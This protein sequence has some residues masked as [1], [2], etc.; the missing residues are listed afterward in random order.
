[1][2]KIIALNKEWL[3]SPLYKSEYLDVDCLA[4]DFASV[5]LPHANIEIPNN[6]FNAEKTRFIST[7]KRYLRLPSSYNGSKLV[8]GFEGILSYAEIYVNGVFVTSH[9]GETPFDVDIT[10]PIKYDYDNIILIKTDS[11]IR[12]DIPSPGF[13]DPVI[14]YGGIHRDVF[15][16][17]YKGEIIAD[18]FIKT[19]DVLDDQKTIEIDV[20]LCEF[21]PDTFVN[22][23]IMDGDGEVVDTLP[24]KA[25]L[26]AK[27]SLRGS[28]SDVVLWDTENPCLYT[29]KI[30]LSRGEKVL[31]TLSQN[32]GFSEK[33]FT[34]TG[35]YLN[36]QPLKLIGLNRVDA[37][38][39]VG[40]SACE[41]MQIEDANLI[42]YTLGCNVVRMLG[43]ASRDF[44]LHCDKI[45][46]LVIEDIASDGYLGKGMWREVLLNNIEEMV[47]RDRNSP[48]IICWG[49]RPSNSPDC[50]ELFFKTSTAAKT[51]DPTRQ[52]LGTRNF[53]GSHM[54][55]D[56]F[57][58][59][60]YNKKRGAV[61]SLTKTGKM[62]VP[63]LV[64]EHTGKSF[65]TKMHDK[66]SV[67]LEQA[68]RHLKIIDQ[69]L[70]SKKICGAIGMSLSDFHSIQYKGCGD[71]INYYG[72][73]DIYRNPKLAFYAYQS[74][75]AKK[76][77]IKL[78]SDMSSDE[79]SL[80]LYAF[81][82]CDY[83]K[84]YRREKDSEAYKEVGTFYPN[85]KKFSSLP[86]P[87]IKL[88]DMLG[89][90][91]IGEGFSKYES[92]LFK[93]LCKAAAE[94]NILN[95]G[96]INKIIMF[97]LRK[98]KKMSFDQFR[99]LLDRHSI[100]PL[101]PVSYKVAGFIG[102]EEV[103]QSVVGSRA[104]TKYK[105]VCE[106]NKIVCGKSMQSVK[107]DVIALS[108]DDNRRWYDF[109]PITVKCSD[110]VMVLGS[111]NFTLVG[112]IASVYIK[113]LAEGASTVTIYKGNEEL[114]QVELEVV[115]ESMESI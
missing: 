85:K 23:I 77:M 88:D 50:A 112:G 56:I 26:S 92:K 51:L 18:A 42:K 38:A 95:F 66:E 48:S 9:K 99:E 82:N 40:R 49:V 91:L 17:V 93:K 1:M 81:T 55:E 24:T 58:F 19:F 87:P 108:G 41:Q 64:A 65:P 110:G 4:D 31:D 104:E 35:F 76:P 100:K 74:Q 12:K 52:T 70:A 71:G 22:A 103:C 101:I 84:L 80:S 83:V 96:I 79:F 86:H 21:Y 73:T 72:I 106:S 15:L 32:F 5:S 53:M 68:M 109:S 16:K 11:N 3:Y 44:I 47:K 90:L 43:L 34:S 36:G 105:I 30:V 69:V 7:Y 29:A 113:A 97:F 111:E 25:V 67:R 45:G 114:G 33:K 20:T 27:M 75:F 54:Y 14:Q 28:I 39:V 60:D 10:A 98:K 102:D 46:L 62:F 89:D 8:L 6:Y 13:G 115:Y 78:S 107:I 63:Y 94:M 61:S 37:Y 2:R 57:G 59:S